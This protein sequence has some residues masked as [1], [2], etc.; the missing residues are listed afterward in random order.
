MV[1]VG[2]HPTARVPEV[3]QVSKALGIGVSA[4]NGRHGES[5]VDNLPLA[6]S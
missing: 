2:M 5:M 1:R 6:F 4:R 3:R